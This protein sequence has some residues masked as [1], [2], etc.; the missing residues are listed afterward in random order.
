MLVAADHSFEWWAYFDGAYS[1]G[2]SANTSSNP[3]Q[4][5][6]VYR[7]S[8]AWPSYSAWKSDVLNRSEVG[9]HTVTFERHLVETD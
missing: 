1:W 3:F 9:S 4:L 6:A 7:S 8:A 5:S 2:T